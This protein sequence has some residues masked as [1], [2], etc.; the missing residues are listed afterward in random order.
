VKEIC[1]IA[2]RHLETAPEAMVSF[3]QGC[4]G[5]PLLEHKLIGEAISAIRGETKRGTIH[6]NTNGALPKELERLVKRGLDSVRI[7]LN[8]CLP[9]RYHVYFAPRGY[10]H[11]DVKRSAK[12]ARKAGAYLHFNLLVF[13]G[14][15]DQPREI[16][17]LLEWIESTGVN[18]IQLKN[19]CIDP[20]AY[21][22]AMPDTQ[23]KGK[24][25]KHLVRILHRDAG[26]VTLGYFNIPKEE[27]NLPRK[28]AKKT[29]V[30]RIGET[31]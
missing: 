10:S 16:D 2:V 19:L 26:H 7:S 13:P 23:E 14:I 21:L 28:S 1:E 5:E 17:A 15:S 24:G 31:P 22:A 12:M 9:E 18:H 27:F 20:D 30:A 6:L 11:F 29:A 3:G 25:T 4:E 8:S